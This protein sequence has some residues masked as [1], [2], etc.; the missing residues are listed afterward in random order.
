MVKSKVTKLPKFSNIVAGILVSLLLWRTKKFKFIKSLKTSESILEIWFEEKS[1]TF[2]NLKPFILPLFK[3]LNSFLEKSN[4]SSFSWSLS[5]SGW[6]SLILLSDK[7]MT[8]SLWT[9]LNIISSNSLIV[10]LLISNRFIFLSF[11]KIR[12]SNSIRLL[13]WRRLQNYESESTIS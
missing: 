3:L 8:T 7:F 5:N 9:W 4:S 13:F 1:T 11:Q 12:W 2:K 10:F 6:K